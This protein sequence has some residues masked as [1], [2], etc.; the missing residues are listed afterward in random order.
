VGEGVG[1]GDEV[2]SLTSVGVGEG[3][4]EE[5]HLL[6]QLSTPASTEL[7]THVSRTGQSI[8]KDTQ[9]FVV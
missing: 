5:E 2:G 7:S 1:V 4:R 3:A 9:F 8:L 6:L